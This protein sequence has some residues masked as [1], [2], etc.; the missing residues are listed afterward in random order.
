MD[1]IEWDDTLSVNVAEIDR[2]HKKLVAMINELHAAMRER[3]TKDVLGKIIDGMITYAETHFATEEKYF[4]QFNYPGTTTHKKEH[5]YFI[6]KV[7]EFKQSFDADRLML[8]IDV[9]DF[10][11]EWLVTHIQGSDKKY[12]S[13]FNKKGLN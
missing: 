3:R 9:I 8:S 2:Q 11:K 4:D 1:L 10:L 13:F 12:S 6:K 5:K 7:N